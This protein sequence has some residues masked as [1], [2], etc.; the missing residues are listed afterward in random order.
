MS[1]N[2]SANAEQVAINIT[3]SGKVQGVG[4]RPFIFR[5]AQ[6]HNINGWVKNCI[7]KVEI[8][9]QGTAQQLDKFQAEI[10]Q[11]SPVQ[12]LISWI[13]FNG[14][15]TEPAHDTEIQAINRFALQLFDRLTNTP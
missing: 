8:H 10:Y 11:A 1:E 2:A 12:P 7:G 13:D 6:Q 4:F 15:G 5:L 9:A 3:L 14:Q